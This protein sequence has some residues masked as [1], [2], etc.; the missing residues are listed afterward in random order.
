M[1]DYSFEYTTLFDKIELLEHIVIELRKRIEFLE[2]ENISTCNS[3]YELE[4][5]LDVL[6][7]HNE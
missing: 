7:Y 1:T 3:I 5:S 6:K 4:N 2:G